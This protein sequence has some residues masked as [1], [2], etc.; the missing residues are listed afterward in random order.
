MDK[1]QIRELISV[2]NRL[3][4][5]DAQQGFYEA[6]CWKDIRTQRDMLFRELHSPREKTS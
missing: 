1:Q 2:L 6:P 3:I 4:E 5:W